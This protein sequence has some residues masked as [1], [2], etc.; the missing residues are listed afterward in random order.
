[1]RKHTVWINLTEAC[2]NRCIWCYGG[3][4]FSSNK[5]MDYSVLN[6][7]FKWL[8]NIDISS[9]ILIG[10]EPTLYPKIIDTIKMGTSLGI[11][12]AIV[13]NG[14]MFS[15]LS[16][17]KKVKEAGIEP[18]QIALSMSSPSSAMA[19]SLTGNQNSFYVF[20]K[21]LRNLV[22][23]DLDPGV[24]IV[25]SNLLIDYIE[26]M[27]DW[28][29]ENGGNRI[30]INL[31]VPAISSELI[32]T[33]FGLPLES[34]AKKTVEISE[35]CKNKKVSVSFLFN[36]PYC[37]LGYDELRILLEERVIR[38]G[39]GVRSGNSVIFNVNGDL[40]SCNHIPDYVI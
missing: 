22:S 19:K 10:G 31:V 8:T 9:C 38:S 4:T 28:V 39:C 6:Q 20:S 40:I 11:R 30:V 34:L 29:E 25:L 12:M 18:K 23:L 1:M 33:S 14:I 5:H 13:S 21:A 24:N 2:N 16:F 3:Q 36:I 27:I 32:D 26:D 7:I 15:D 35:Y 17:C 37:I